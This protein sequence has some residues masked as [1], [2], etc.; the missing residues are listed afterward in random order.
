[1]Q[2]VRPIKVNDLVMYP[3]PPSN[4]NIPSVTYRPYFLKHCWFT[5]ITYFIEPWLHSLRYGRIKIVPHVA[6]SDV[7]LFLF[8][9]YVK[10][11]FYVLSCIL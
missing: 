10:L 4:I 11:F 1:M 6:I 7:Y 5:F 8:I 9:F 3:P 2:L